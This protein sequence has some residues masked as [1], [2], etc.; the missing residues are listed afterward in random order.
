LKK[1][2]K[3]ANQPKK[4]NSKSSSKGELLAAAVAPFDRGSVSIKP[5]PVPVYE[6]REQREVSHQGIGQLLS[7]ARMQWQFAEWER[8]CQ[9]DI[10]HI[11]HHPDR[12]ELALLAG[13]AALQLGVQEKAATY[14]KAA[15]GWGCDERLMFQLLISGVHNSMGQ[16]HGL[17]GNNQK[18]EKMLQLGGIGL[19]GDVTLISEIRRSKESSRL[20]I[21]EKVSSQRITELLAPL[22]VETSH[23]DEAQEEEFSME[24]AIEEAS[25]AESPFKEGITSYAQNFEDVMLWRALGHVKNG[26]YID[27][28]AQHP[29]TDSVSKAFY[30]K[31]WRGI[32]VEAN[33]AYAKLLRKDRPDEIVIQAIL[34]NNHNKKILHTINESGLSTC[35]EEIANLHSCNGYIVNK[36]TYRTIT[37]NDVLGFAKKEINF[38]KI[39]IEGMEHK[40]LHKNYIFC[41]KPWII[42]VEATIPNSSVRIDSLFQKCLNINN[43]KQVYFDGLSS[44]YLSEEKKE[45][46]I[47][48]TTPVNIFDLYK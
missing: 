30:E 14:V 33:P 42:V 37:L 18:A 23:P 6:V 47:F 31:G 8:L 26:F 46:E 10:L 38:L 5:K 25:R 4:K 40:I 20:G 2:S 27:I 36:V 28:G 12:A 22:P 3:A 1:A 7:Q 48:F 44:Y 24:K 21:S 17:K 19:G 11:E 32:H 15:R 34:S 43:Y 16:Y 29:V 35:I 39:D 45:L 41:K 9:L 13:C